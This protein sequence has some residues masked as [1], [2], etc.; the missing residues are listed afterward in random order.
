MLTNNI[1]TH[2]V[3]LN[4]K[5]KAWYIIIRN[6]SAIFMAHW[7]SCI[8]IATMFISALLKVKTKASCTK[9]IDPNANFTHHKSSCLATVTMFISVLLRVKTNAK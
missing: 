5:P 2:T 8:A 4:A 1:L 9:L 6:S 3:S 7:P